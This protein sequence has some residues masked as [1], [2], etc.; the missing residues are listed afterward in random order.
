MLGRSPGTCFEVGSMKVSQGGLGRAGVCPLF[1]C[2]TL[3]EVQ[4]HTRDPRGCHVT[5]GVE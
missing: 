1:I 3:P 2:R 5:R 4:R